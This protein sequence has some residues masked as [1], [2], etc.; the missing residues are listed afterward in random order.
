MG[1]RNIYPE[2]VN[3]WEALMK[4]RKTP[5]TEAVFRRPGSRRRCVKFETTVD[6]YGTEW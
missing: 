2:F 4:K 3:K 5:R 1:K 6:L